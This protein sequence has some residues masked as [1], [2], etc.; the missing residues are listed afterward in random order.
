MTFGISHS[1]RSSAS[2]S[3]FLSRG[4]RRLTFM[5]IDQEV[6]AASVSSVYRV[7]AGNGL[8]DR[9]NKKRSKKGTGFVQPLRPHEHCVHGGLTVTFQ[10]T[11]HAVSDV[12]GQCHLWSVPSPVSGQCRLWS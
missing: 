3:G 4:Y 8:L 9:W 7:L 6:V 1:A 10:P 11:Q 12:S 2:T 5:R